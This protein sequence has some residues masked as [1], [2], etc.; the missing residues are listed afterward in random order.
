MPAGQPGGASGSEPLIE[1]HAAVG[2]PRA[3]GERCPYIL[4]APV[5]RMTLAFALGHGLSRPY[6]YR[7]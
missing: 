1:V 4:S 3:G 7:F 6:G 5:N 2:L